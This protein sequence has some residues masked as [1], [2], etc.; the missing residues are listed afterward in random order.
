MRTFS[1][2]T[3]RNLFAVV[4]IVG[5]GYL[6]YTANPASVTG[7]KVEAGN[8]D[9]VSG[10][11]Y[12]ETIGWISFNS[13]N[14]SSGSSYGVN[15]S[16][17][18]GTGFFSG[19]A[20]SRG[21]TE[22]G[23]VGWISFDQADTA[24]CVTAYGGTRAQ[25]DWST[26]AVT[27]WARAL[28]GSTASGWD[29][30]IKLAKAPSDTGAAYGVSISPSDGKFSGWAWGSD[31]VGWISFA[32]STLGPNSYFVQGPSSVVVCGT[33]QVYDTD[34]GACMPC[35][36]NGCSGSGATSLDPNGA[37]GSLYC[38]VTGTFPPTCSCVSPNTVFNGQCVASCPNGA[39][40]A[41]SCA[42]CPS[43]QTFNASN[44][45][46]NVKPKYQQF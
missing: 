10:W 37:N 41:S 40:V 46:A 44:Q 2:H 39:T 16:P 1:I 20:W 35:G 13:T 15:I 24:T 25:V 19:S 18:T 21:T 28:S 3:V 22:N 6:A 38:N 43:G 36:G 5:L 45:C 12:S 8:G 32:D 4:V 26:G 33:G 27:G 14:E 11:A 9:N 30:C 29:G 17:T 42:T 7:P 23:G 31:V 34:T